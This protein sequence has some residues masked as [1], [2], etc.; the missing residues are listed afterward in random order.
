MISKNKVLII[1]LG[2]SETLDP[3]ISKECS[4]GDVVRT[5][6]ILNYFKEHDNITWLVDEEALPLLEGNNYIDRILLWNLETSLQLQREKFDV[7][8]NLEKGAGICAMADNIDAWHKVGFRLSDWLGRAEAHYHT[9]QVLAIAQNQDKRDNNK[10][11]WQ[12]HLAR[13]LDKRWSIKDRYLMNQPCGEV[14]H[15]FG[16]NWKVGNKWPDKAWSKD[17]WLELKHTLE[18]SGKTVSLQPELTLKDYMDW[19]YS[20]GCI[21]SCDSLGM[22]LSI[23]Y[24]RNTIGLFG[25]T[26]GKE[27]YFYGKGEALTA[28]DGK[29][30]SITVE[31]VVEAIGR[32][33]GYKVDSTIAKGV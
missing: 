25:P 12:E 26:Q 31:T 16:L 2:H 21:V 17:K 6:V 5:T 22:H 27:V 8:V 9:E 20:C 7:V 28:E 13:V 3:I 29:M 32:M 11:Y 15:E 1:K 10:K 24:G 14:K 23:G 18:A 19:I 4:L 30:D 33:N